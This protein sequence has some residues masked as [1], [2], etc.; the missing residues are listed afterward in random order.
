MNLD[1]QVQFIKG[2]G[3]KRAQALSKLG[4]NTVCDLI[5]NFPVQYQDRRNITPIAKAYIRPQNTIFGKIGKLHERKLSVSLSIL[6]I[7]I[8]DNTGMAYARFFRKKN[9]YSKIDVFGTIKK[10]FVEGCYAYIYGDSKAEIGAKYI[11]VNDYEIVE[12][13]ELIPASFNKILPVYA[14]TEGLSQKVIR[15]AI[16]SALIQTTDLYPDI[17]EIIPEFN[18]V[19]RLKSGDAIRQIHYP[20][21]FKEAEVARRSFAMQEFFVLETALAI[22]RYSNKQTPKKQKYEIKRTLLTPFKNELNFEFTKSQKKVINEIFEDMQKKFPMNRLL[23]GDVGSGKTVVALSAILLAVENGYQAMIIAPTEIL[24]EQHYNTISKI[25]KT[26]NISCEL[27]T[28]ATLR[29]KSAKEKIL[30]DI[31]SGKTNVVIGTHALIEERVGFKNLSLVVVDE[32]HRFGVLQKSAAVDKAQT[33]DILMMTATPIPRALAMTV[34]GEMDISTINELPPGRI[35]VKTYIVSEALAYNKT[36]EELE[37]GGQAYIVYPLIDESDKV[38]LKSAVK[39]AA[40]LSTG[41]FKDF[42]VGLLHGKMKSEEKNQTMQDFKDKKI[43]VLISTTVIEVGIDVPNATIIIIEH[44]ERFGLSA[45]HQ[46]RGRIGRG[47]K[48]SYCYLIGSTKGENA[49]QR[50]SIMAQTNNGF[51]IAEKDLEMRGP[52]EFMGT[53][54]HG[55]P[56]FKAGNLVKDTDIIDFSKNFAKKLVEEDPI[57]TKPAHQILKKLIIER[58]KNKIKLTNVG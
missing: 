51:E 41:K 16:K 54:Q 39:E 53:L 33:A 25:L 43:D 18:G 49:F 27:V 19:K 6:D 8:F 32:Q 48:Q 52:G 38:A 11:S 55:F 34:Y 29:K 15:E 2:I 42:K 9:P 30:S 40:K 1:T 24:A 22:S 28:S 31:K 20:I 26:L 46:L 21:G 17:S 37:N 14:A 57:L 58:F 50:L 56:E 10:A 13:P 7:E 36:I 47:Q 23:M 4:L 44:A 45:L 3:P 35:P 5:L 12:K